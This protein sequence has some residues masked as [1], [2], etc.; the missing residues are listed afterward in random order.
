[1]K[2]SSV[3]KYLRL[4]VMCMCA[5]VF[6]Q[7][8]YLRW[9][10]YDALLALSGLTNAEFGFTMSVFGIIGLICYLPGGIIADKVQPRILISVSLVVVGACGI[11]LTFGPDYLTQLIIYS[12]MAFAANL[13][14]WSALMKATRMLETKDGKGK[15]F[16][17]LEG[18]RAFSKLSLRLLL[19]SS[20]VLLSMKSMGSSSFL[21]D[22]RYLISFLRLLHFSL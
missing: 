18:G 3:T 9:T 1:M 6:Y 5:V 21:S 16:G 7:V 10:F 20:S 13:L 22:T 2:S 8:I 4:A 15:M 14:F 17:L 19:F 11:W 12:I